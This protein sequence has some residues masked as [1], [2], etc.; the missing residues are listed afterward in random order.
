MNFHLYAE[1]WEIKKSPKILHNT[2][3]LKNAQFFKKIFSN[4]ENFQNLLKNNFEKLYFFQ[5]LLKEHFKSKKPKFSK[6]K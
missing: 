2:R 3:N 5:T 1:F 4:L 6:V